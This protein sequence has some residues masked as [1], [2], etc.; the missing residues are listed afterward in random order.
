VVLVHRISAFSETVK[1]YLE[2][3]LLG[4]LRHRIYYGMNCV[5]SN[6]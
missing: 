5:H 4:G 1:Q 3:D 2:S 6:S